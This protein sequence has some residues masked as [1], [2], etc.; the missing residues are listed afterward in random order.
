MTRREESE[1]LPLR[2]AEAAGAS[3]PHQPPCEPA[4]R[5][6][7]RGQR[8]PG[9]LAALALACC[10]AAAAPALAANPPA[11][12]PGA[13]VSA[14]LLAAGADPTGAHDVSQ[15]FNK[16]L[17]SGVRRITVPS[18]RYLLDGT[19]TVALND[20]EIDCEGAPASANI[21]ARAGAYGHQGAT[22]WLTSTSVQPF[23]IGPNGARIKYCNFFWPNQT[24][25][26]R[27]PVAYP[28][29]FTEVKGQQMS[30]LELISD[31]IINAYDVIGQTSASDVYGDIKLE[32]TTGYAVRYWLNLANVQEYIWVSG[33]NADWNLFQG[34]AGFSNNHH[35]AD[36]T[37]AHGAF[38][39]AFGNGD[40]KKASTV[41]V[42][43]FNFYGGLFAYSRAIWVDP[44]GNV[45][46]VKFHGTYDAVPRVLEVDDG[47]C[48]ADVE[49][50][51][52]FYAYQ[53][54]AAGT[55]NAPMI[56]VNTS[57]NGCVATGLRFTGHLFKAQGDV[58]DLSGSSVKG[59]FVG[60]SGAGGFASTTTPGGTYY[61][62][63]VN[64]PYAI[65]DAIGNHLEPGGPAGNARQGFFIQAAYSVNITGNSFN[66]VY[67]PIK[68]ASPNTA[69]VAA[70]NVSVGTPAGG[71]ISGAGSFAHAILL[72]NT[73][74]PNAVSAPTLSTCGASPSVTGAS[75][76]AGTIHVGGGAGGT[77]TLNFTNAFG[78]AGPRCFFSGT[79]NGSLF[80][81]ALSRNAVTVSSSANL[82]GSTIWYRCEP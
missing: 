82:A 75:D 12:A 36:W 22:F 70:G 3:H 32:D 15:V 6:A 73:W 55:D 8:R 13:D 42:G 18:G 78:P 54:N 17:A 27:D 57:A 24:G 71:A 16:L 69:V 9:V 1:A 26:N 4:R 35:L 72:G 30:N 25:V 48:A 64:A 29:L 80:V 46:E 45:N 11:A 53:Y 56:S 20:V 79:A 77:C 40:G 34:V 68:I 37:A 51:G 67:A 52:E 21:T 44:T 31:R 65:F 10:A 61:F 58:I 33:M 60:I 14:S 5:Q 50:D 43:G 76:A 7:L 81:S 63:N 59:V 28:P 19:A 47:G 23:T 39:H 62:A 66:G 74:D 2:A 49:I 38:L 41:G